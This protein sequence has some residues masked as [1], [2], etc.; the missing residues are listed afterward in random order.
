MVTVVKRRQNEQ[1]Y[2]EEKWLWER[3]LSVENSNR[4]RGNKRKMGYDLLVTPISRLWFDIYLK[5]Y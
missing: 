2:D 1:W 5:Y 4:Y 3:W